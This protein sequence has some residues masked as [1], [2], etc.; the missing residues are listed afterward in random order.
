LRKHRVF[1]PQVSE[2][3][4]ARTVPSMAGVTSTATLLGISVSL[5]S[6]VPIGSPKVQA[7]I[8]TFDQSYEQAVES[9]LLA[10][11]P[12]GSINLA[13]N[14]PAFDAAVVKALDTLATDLVQTLGNV[15]PTSAVATQVVDA[16]T[17]NSPNSLESQLLALPTQA[18]ESTTTI[19][20]ASI[21]LVHG[22]PVP[23]VTFVGS[24]E[25]ARPMT[26]VPV[27]QAAPSV[28]QEIGGLTTG[29]STDAAQEI[30][31][32]FGAFLDDYFQAMKAVLLANQ[33]GT[34]NPQATRADFDAHVSKA[35]QAL[36]GSLS[37][38]LSRYP[39]AWGLAS[40]IR[41]S[42]A[43]DQAASLKSQLKGLPTPAGPQAAIVRDFTMGSIKLVADALS[44]ITGN[45]S[46]A[47]NP[48]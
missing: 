25:Q 19:V 17:G 9:V 45:V 5:P 40:Q 38:T 29:A 39:A 8:N 47:L 21:P 10:P 48:R 30:R 27:A 6:Q 22:T 13:A 23:L 3:L 24:A 34:V 12:G 4:E 44:M 20:S 31:K 16:I 32:A 1:R 28:G 26:R 35:L 7:I 14:R 37:G 36:G 42:I 43:S 11:G 2:L 33:G 46:Q 41:E 18:I 15:A